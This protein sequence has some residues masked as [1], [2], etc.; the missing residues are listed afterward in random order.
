MALELVSYD[1]LKALLQLK[2][3]NISKYPDLKLLKDSVEVAIEAAAGRE[4]EE[5]DRVE[6][7]QIGL[8]GSTRVY[9]NAIPITAVAS[10]M[11]DGEALTVDDY[12]VTAGGL[13]LAEKYYDVDVVVTYT[14]GCTQKTLPPTA[15]RAA[16]LQTAYEYQNKEHI[17]ASS[18][19]TEGGSVNS[20]AL[21]LLP[22]V[23]KL[24]ARFKHPWLGVI[25]V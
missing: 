4:F 3:D 1:D 16:L 17:G 7:V 19:Q 18:V 11:V 9:L 20:P 15:S 2:G 5:D 14:G 12:K 10:V 13:R 6:T 21:Q 23:R 22:V 8:C 24:I 25:G